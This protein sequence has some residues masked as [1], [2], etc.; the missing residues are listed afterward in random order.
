MRSLRVNVWIGDISMRE[1]KLENIL[2]ESGKRLVEALELLND[3]MPV[4]NNVRKSKIIFNI[5][6]GTK[7]TIQIQIYQDG[8][9]W[10]S[11]LGK[12]VFQELIK[13][14][15]EFG[16]FGI[17]DE[18]DRVFIG[19]DVE[20][21]STCMEFTF[22]NTMLIDKELTDIGVANYEAERLNELMRVLSE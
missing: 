2:S 5:L 19:K 17:D 20:L 10:T 21:Y 9:P 4:E 6:E 11:Y 14:A 7:S 3:F 16:V 15:D 22:N 13:L 1:V 12:L 18:L 8:S